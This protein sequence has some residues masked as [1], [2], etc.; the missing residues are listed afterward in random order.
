MG[1]KRQLQMFEKT[2][3]E[4]MTQFTKETLL[5]VRSLEANFHEKFTDI[6]LEIKKI[7]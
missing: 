4:T 1:L 2:T 7:D 5:N 3:S 6:L